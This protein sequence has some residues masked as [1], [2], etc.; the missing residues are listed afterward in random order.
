[1][2]LFTSSLSNFGKI[3]IFNAA[4]LLRR[5]MRFACDIRCN[6]QNYC[7]PV[8]SK[9]LAKNCSP[10]PN[11]NTFKCFLKKFCRVRSCS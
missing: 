2:P 3:S 1:M 9:L 5:K 7:S 11:P 8:K 10:N 6:Y 4:D